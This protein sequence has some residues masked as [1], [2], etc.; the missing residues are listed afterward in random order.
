MVILMTVLFLILATFFF[1]KNNSRKNLNLPPVVK[2]WPLVGALYMLA[3]DPVNLIRKNYQKHG[4][5]FTVKVFGQS[6]TLL[7]GPEV[8]KH[9]YTAPDSELS[10]DE[11]RQSTIP[12]FGPNVFIGAPTELRQQQTQFLLKGLRPQLLRCYVDQIVAEVQD[13]FSKWLDCGTVNLVHEL[14]HLITLTSSRCL[15]GRDV[16]NNLNEE[17][18]ALVED[19]A[20]GLRPIKEQK[21][22]LAR[23][24][25]KIDFDILKEMDVLYRCIKEALR[26]GI[27]P[28]IIPRYCHKNFTVST[29][30]GNE[31]TIPKGHIVATSLVAAHRVDHVFKDP[32]RYDPDRH[33][34]AGQKDMPSQPFSFIAFGGGRHTCPGEAFSYLQLKIIWSYLIRN[35]DLD[36]VSAFSVGEWDGTDELLVHYKRRHLSI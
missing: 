21:T 20:G 3:K 31:Y 10:Q 17:V 28:V 30:E 4:S 27:T 8:S 18:T 29:K 6:I 5:V 34:P 7:I 12:M 22:L 25:L 14:E 24:G 11:L 9:F 32:G 1:R 26:I 16:R 13:Y 15:L 36:L 23:H 35:F 19:I 33:L 2:S